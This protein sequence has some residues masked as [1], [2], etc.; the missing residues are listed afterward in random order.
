MDP[1][2]KNQN[3]FYVAGNLEINFI[4]YYIIFN[5]AQIKVNY[6]LFEK[7]YLT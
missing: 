3:F 2:I 6:I 7:C 4:A 1:V 5:E